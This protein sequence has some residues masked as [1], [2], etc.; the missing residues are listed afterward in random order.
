VKALITFGVIG[1]VL[2]AYAQLTSISLVVV[3]DIHPHYFLY[4]YGGYAPPHYVRDWTVGLVWAMIGAILV[5]IGV[6]RLRRS[7]KAGN[8]AA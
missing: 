5:G 3:R 4:D 6:H 1:L 8:G 7:G 2:Y